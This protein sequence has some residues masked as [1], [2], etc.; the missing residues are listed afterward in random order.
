MAFT[1]KDG[2]RLSLYPAFAGTLTARQAS[3]H[4]ADRSVA[5]P[6]GLLTLRFDPGRFPPKPA[7][8]YRAS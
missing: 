3:L 5:P 4:A 1:L 2:A 8:C 6:E 7:A